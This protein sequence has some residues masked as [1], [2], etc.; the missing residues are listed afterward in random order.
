MELTELINVEIGIL[1]N[2]SNFKIYS[3]VKPTKGL[4]A[5]CEQFGY[6]EELKEYVRNI[7]DSLNNDK[8]I[9]LNFYSDIFK[10]EEKN[11]TESGLRIDYN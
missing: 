1:E 5:L 4:I 9:H 10:E 7:S 3:K 11:G 6:E 2:G 8:N